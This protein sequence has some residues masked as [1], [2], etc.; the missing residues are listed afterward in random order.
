MPERKIL[1][2]KADHG[3]INAILSGMK[4]KKRGAYAVPQGRRGFF[5]GVINFCHP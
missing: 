3:P 1:G 4:E 2:Q 5:L